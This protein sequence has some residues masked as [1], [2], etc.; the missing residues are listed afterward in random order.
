MS[1][2]IRYCEE[3]NNKLIR[4]SEYRV[5]IL[6]ASLEIDLNSSIYFKIEIRP[7]YGK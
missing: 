5:K 3:I 2:Y 1:E 4:L 6:N 7:N